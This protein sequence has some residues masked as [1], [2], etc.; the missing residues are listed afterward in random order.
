MQIQLAP[1]RFDVTPPIGHSLC[2]GWIEPVREVNDALEALG[3]VI[4]GAGSPVVICAVDWTGLCN[5]A[6]LKWREELARAAETTPDR[7]AVHCVHQ[8]DAPFV[9]LDAQRYVLAEGDLPDIVQA[10]FFEDCL[11]RAQHAIQEAIRRARPVSHIGHGQ[12]KVDQVASNRRIARDH[13]GRVAAER[14][15][16]C[17]DEELRAMPEGLID[18][19]L[20][21][22]AFFERDQAVAT[23]HYYATHPQSYYG[24]GQVSSDFVGLARKQRQQED[25]N[26]L[27]IFFTGCAGNIS[28]GKYNDGSPEA[29][30]Q[31]TMRLYDAIVESERNIETDGVHNIEWRTAE[32]TPVPRATLAQAALLEQLTNRYYTSGIRGRAAFI[33]AW[34]ECLERGHVLTLSTLRVNDVSMLH[35]PAECF[36]EYQLRAQESVPG[37][38]VATA[39]YGDG[40][41]WYIPVKEEYENGGYELTSTLC[42]SGI[43]ALVSEAIQELLR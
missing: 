8:H 33:L 21:T 23:C 35:L 22:V 37:R 17:R 11:S 3:F 38:F 13:K 27:H 36:V 2:G 20:K 41:P 1:F 10:E 18:P 7:V 19:W 29:R 5:T 4:L 9:C 32:V 28:A 30:K 42:D 26:C 16:F 40:G 12:S 43:D 25:A 6:H 15:S 39:A 24:E 31:L 14:R 34:K